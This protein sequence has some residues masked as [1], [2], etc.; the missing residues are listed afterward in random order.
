M[1]PFGVKILKDLDPPANFVGASISIDAKVINIGSMPIFNVELNT[2]EDTFSDISEGE[3]TFSAEILKKGEKLGSPQ[4]AML[5]SQGQFEAL[6][7]TVS[8]TLAGQSFSRSSEARSM[9][10]YSPISAEVVIDS[11]IP[12]EGEKFSIT[13]TVSN[14]SEVIVNDVLVKFTLPPEV[15]II[16]GSLDLEGGVLDRDSEITKSAKL[17][18]DKPMTLSI[19]SPIVEFSYAEESLNGTSNSLIIYVGDNIQ[20]RYFIPTLIAVFLI[21]GT[22]YIARKVL[23]SN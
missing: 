2:G 5:T 13:L 14:P 11:V 23:V 21:L 8:F 12:I 6:Q 18:V 22:T 4:K 19:E 9:S 3:T 7:A 16:S 17:I 10:I 20:S 15:R 1:L